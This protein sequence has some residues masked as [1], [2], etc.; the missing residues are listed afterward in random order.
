MN[1]GYYNISLK[2]KDE[3]NNSE[4]GKII[5]NILHN[6]ALISF[7]MFLHDFVNFDEETISEVYEINIYHDLTIYETE[8]IVK[9]LSNISEIRVF[10]KFEENNEVI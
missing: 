1:N 4:F 2:P 6:F 7:T 9:A 10:D 8:Q 3:F 5:G